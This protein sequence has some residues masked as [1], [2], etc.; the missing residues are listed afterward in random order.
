[1]LS[2]DNTTHVKNL[3]MIYAVLLILRE[4]INTD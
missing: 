3:T 1:M 2:Y 4:N